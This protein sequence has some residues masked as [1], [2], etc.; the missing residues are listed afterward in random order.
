MGLF[1]AV[2]LAA[3]KNERVSNFFILKNGVRFAVTQCIKSLLNLISFLV[4]LVLRRTEGL[5]TRQFDLFALI[6]FR[7]NHETIVSSHKIYAHAKF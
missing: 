7:R 5:T 4:V 2:K 3:L 1:Y 6:V